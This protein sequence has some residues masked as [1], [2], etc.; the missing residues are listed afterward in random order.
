MPL[1]YSIIKLRWMQF[2]NMAFAICGIVGAVYG[3]GK[4]PEVLSH[5]PDGVRRGLLVGGRNK[6]FYSFSIFIFIFIFYFF[7]VQSLLTAM[8]DSVGG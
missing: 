2:F 8:A 7:E 5:R 4:T 1:K 3:M 6:H